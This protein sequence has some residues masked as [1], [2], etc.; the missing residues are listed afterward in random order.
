[1]LNHRPG[2]LTHFQWSGTGQLVA[3][4]AGS[5]EKGKPVEINYGGKGNGELLTYFGFC[6]PDNP[7][8]VLPL[9]ISATLADGSIAH[10][11]INL[12]KAQEGAHPTESISAYALDTIRNMLEPT[13]VQPTDQWAN[14]P[15]SL[16]YCEGSLSVPSEFGFEMQLEIGE[17]K[18]VL[19]EQ[20]TLQLLLLRLTK[21]VELLT[22]ASAQ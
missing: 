2:A 18:N 3:H 16:V 12:H 7:A 15:V 11:S 13:P 6:L 14:D 8:D 5:I 20:R 4:T 19:N 10:C 9:S 1:M 22:E 21:E 17:P